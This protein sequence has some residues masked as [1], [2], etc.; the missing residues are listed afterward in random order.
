M[1]RLVQLVIAIQAENKFK[2]QGILPL[3]LISDLLFDD[4]YRIA[5]KHDISYGT[6]IKF[7]NNL[8]ANKCN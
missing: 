3:N 2:K 7:K 6:W 8:E 1:R 4:L 5:S